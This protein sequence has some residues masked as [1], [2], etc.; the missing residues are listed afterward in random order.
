MG[1]A[2]FSINRFDKRQ[3]STA[4]RSWVATQHIKPFERPMYPLNDDNLQDQNQ[5]DDD[6]DF[7]ITEDQ[8]QQS[9][10][11]RFQTPALQYNP[12]YQRT[13]MLTQY[14]HN[15]QSGDV[16]DSVI[17]QS[18]SYGQVTPT[19]TPGRVLRSETAN[20]EGGLRSTWGQPVQF[21]CKK[22]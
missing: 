12:A 13:P 21:D 14:A 3:I 20:E 5:V 17:G 9:T 1:F 16:T 22:L 10:R 7:M 18:S 8:Q 6:Y 19:D 11:L 2:P 15:P 4:A